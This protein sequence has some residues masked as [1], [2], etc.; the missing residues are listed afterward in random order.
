M[1]LWCRGSMLGSHAKGLWIKSRSSK[2]FYF[3][4]MIKYFSSAQISYFHIQRGWLPKTLDLIFGVL[5][6]LHESILLIFGQEMPKSMCLVT[7][8]F[9]S[10]KSKVDIFRKKFF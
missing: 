7:V 9:I 6:L 8:R 1:S 10:P 4:F 3:L 2:H 5:G